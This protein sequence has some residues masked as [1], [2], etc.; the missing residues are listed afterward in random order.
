MVTQNPLN[1]AKLK[2]ATRRPTPVYPTRSAVKI[3]KNAVFRR[4]F[5]DLR[6]EL[7][8]TAQIYAE[9]YSVYTVVLSSYTAFLR[10]YAFFICYLPYKSLQHFEESTIS[11]TIESLSATAPTFFILRQQQH[12]G[13]C[14][15]IP[16]AEMLTAEL[17]LSPPPPNFFYCS[18]PPHFQRYTDGFQKTGRIITCRNPSYIATISEQRT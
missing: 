3:A 5:S 4:I 14:D 13:G 18:P 1:N 12:M 6:E 16:K 9:L 2:L 11:T 15:M 10:S 17:L 7:I 8:P